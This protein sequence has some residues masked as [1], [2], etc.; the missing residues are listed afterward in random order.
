MKHVFFPDGLKAIRG[1]PG[2]FLDPKTRV[3]YS[4]KCGG[5]LRPIKKFRH[6]VIPNMFGWKVS[7]NGVKR[8]IRD[9]LVDKWLIESYHV[10]VK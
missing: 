2:Y 3:L 1:F 7:V 5:E 10:P 4:I 9:D 8:F 6:W